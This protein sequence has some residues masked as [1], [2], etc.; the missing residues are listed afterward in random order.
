VRTGMTH[1]HPRDE[2][3]HEVEMR[4]ELG[5]SGASAPS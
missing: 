1:P 2:T 3:I 4:A 5:E